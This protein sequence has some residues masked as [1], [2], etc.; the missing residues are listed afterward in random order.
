MGQNGGGGG[1]P[2][3]S[4]RG[5]AMRNMSLNGMSR[6]EKRASWGTA[7]AMG[8][9]GVGKARMGARECEGR[10]VRQLS[11]LW[12][13]AQGGRPVGEGVAVM[14]GVGHGIGGMQ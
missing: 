1:S 4:P 6:A 12:R 13:Y 11:R 9:D 5:N 3:V 7:G 2:E 14:N 10:T 8:I